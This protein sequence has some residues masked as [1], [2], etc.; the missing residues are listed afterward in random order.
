VVNVTVVSNCSFNF[1]L[2]R[3]ILATSYAKKCCNI[4]N[5]DLPRSQVKE[6]QESSCSHYASVKGVPEGPCKGS[7][8][9]VRADFVPFKHSSDSQPCQCSACV[10]AMASYLT[11]VSWLL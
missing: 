8:D 6:E 5:A 10:G 1:F 7:H 3:V 4:I 2:I 9:E 11:P